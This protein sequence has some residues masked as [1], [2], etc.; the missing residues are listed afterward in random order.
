MMTEYSLSDV[1]ERIYQNQLALEAALMELTLQV[2]AQ[3]HADVGDNVRGALEAIGENAGHIKQGLARLN[4]LHEA[5]T[6]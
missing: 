5:G 4:K 6:I 3:G 1:L 2:E